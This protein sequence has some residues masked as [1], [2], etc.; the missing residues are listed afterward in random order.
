MGT[1]LG[2]FVKIDEAKLKYDHVGMGNCLFKS[3]RPFQL[4]V[5]CLQHARTGRIFFVENIEYVLMASRSISMHQ[6]AGPDHDLFRPVCKFTPTN[7][8]HASC[9]GI[10]LLNERS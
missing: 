3:G 5:L 6:A 4:I 9:R 8:E 2:Q 7:D 1:G 10:A